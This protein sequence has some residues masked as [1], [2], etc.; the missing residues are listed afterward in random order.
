[1]E[2]VAVAEMGAGKEQGTHSCL[3]GLARESGT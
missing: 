2:G 3:V 1:M